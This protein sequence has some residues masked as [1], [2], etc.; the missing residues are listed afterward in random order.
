[1]KS[2]RI[3]WDSMRILFLV[4]HIYVIPVVG[5]VGNIHVTPIHITLTLTSREGSQFFCNGKHS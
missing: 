3:Y 5:I 2:I 4:A 1:M